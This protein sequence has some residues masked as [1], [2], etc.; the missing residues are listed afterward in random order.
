MIT[1]HWV[2]A[3]AGAMFAAFALLGLGDRTNPRRW[4]TSAFWAL[5]ALSMWGGDWLGDLGN[6]VLLLGLV[7]STEK[8]MQGGAR[9]CC[10][11]SR[12]PMPKMSIEYNQRSPR[13]GN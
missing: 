13:S 7:A 2:Y 11:V 12:S 8:P 1:L 5:L 10:P 6:G 3:V 4:T 9:L